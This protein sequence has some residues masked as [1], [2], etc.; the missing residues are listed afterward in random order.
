MQVEP[1]DLGVYIKD[2]VRHEDDRGTFEEIYNN[3][4]FWEYWST[5]DPEQIN[6]SVSKKNVV[7]GIHCSPYYKIC[8]CISG[9]LFE[10]VV[11]LRPE[12]P[13]HLD[14][15]GFWLDAKNPKAAFVPANCG[16]GFFS[17]IED[18]VLLYAQGGVYDE[19]TEKDIH[20]QDPTIKVVWPKA[21]RYFLSEKDEAAPFY[22]RNSSECS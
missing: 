22:D 2:I 3:T 16:H 8:T 15:A 18:S 5:N 10:V 12:S 21:K 19:K 7:R 4:N 1:A 9:A 17:A 20:W 11:D 13:T 6:L 14:W